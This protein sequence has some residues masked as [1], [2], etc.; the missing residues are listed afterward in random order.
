[1]K[2][3]LANCPACGGLLEFPLSTALVTVCGYCH[4]VLAH[5]GKNLE[6]HGK[7][8]DLVET[9]S[10]IYCGLNGRFGKKPFEVIGR[11]QY[12]HPAG[13]VWTEWYLKFPADKVRWLAEAQGKWYLLVEKK[14]AENVSLPEFDS[15]EPGHRFELAGGQALIVAERGIATAK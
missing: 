7:V 9:D 2:R 3:K 14:L 8:A 11:V 10:R 12:Q 1:M 15:L 13:G 6:D 4:S 5:E